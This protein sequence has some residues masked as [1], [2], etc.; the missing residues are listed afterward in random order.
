M[1]NQQNEGD[2]DQDLKALKARLKI[3]NDEKPPED[4]DALIQHLMERLEK[5]QDAI[6]VAE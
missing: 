2:E 4:K 3:L 5:T 6:T 1:S